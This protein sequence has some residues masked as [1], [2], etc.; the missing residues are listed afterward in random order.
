MNR[1]A[2]VKAKL[3]GY[4]NTYLK[5]KSKASKTTQKAHP[6]TPPTLPLPPTTKYSSASDSEELEILSPSL[7]YSDSASS[8]WQPPVLQRTH[9][10]MKNN[11]TRFKKCL[12]L[13]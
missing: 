2:K 5:E 6:S 11:N 1:E 7:T 10:Y 12:G 8:N 3:E 4:L 13:G 9:S